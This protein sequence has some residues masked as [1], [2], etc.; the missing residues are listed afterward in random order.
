MSTQITESVKPSATPAQLLF[1]YGWIN[2]V[3]ASLAMIATFPGRTIGLSMINRP[4]QQDLHIGDVFQGSLNFWSVLLGAA[5]CWPVGRLLDRFGARLVLTAIIAA[6]GATVLWMSTVHQSEELFLSLTLTRGLGQGA[7]SLVSLALVGKWFRRRIE[8]AMGIFSVLLAIGFIA[9]TVGL[10]ES[11]KAYGW[12]TPWA[13]LGWVMLAG[14]APIS[15]VFVRSRPED[16]WSDPR[17]FPAEAAVSTLVAD[18][19][20]G[21]A[22]RTPAFW[23][24]TLS[25]SLFNMI[26]SGFTFFAETILDEHG[27]DHDTFTLVMALLALNGIVFNLLGG[28][29][30]RF[31]SLGK[32]LA[33]GMVLLALALVAFPLIHGQPGSADRSPQAALLIDGALL[34]G[35]GGVITVVFFAMYNRLFGRRH[36]GQIQGAAQV[37]SVFA[38]ASG[39]LLLAWSRAHTGSHHVMFVTTAALSCLFAIACWFVPLPSHFR[40]RL[41]TP[42]QAQ[43]AEEES[44]GRDQQVFKAARG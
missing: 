15:L 4:L 13:G 28:W 29:V 26:F 19:T 41:L 1:H 27:F 39:P 36:L 3:L 10:G 43:P 33:V 5:F 22:L 31:W 40:S 30:S 11:V 20:L 21:T 35:A 23:V 14:L 38:S 44:G 17:E 6:L 7:L 8:P 34:G 24:F 9:V 2:L 25:T 16:G 42:I 12:R 37:L 18:A 32:L